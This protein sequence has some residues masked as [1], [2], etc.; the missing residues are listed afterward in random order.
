MSQQKSPTLTIPQ[1]PLG[2]PA[3]T[4]Y[5]YGIVTYED[6]FGGKRYMRFRLTWGGPDK[7]SFIK[8]GESF[9]VLFPNPEGNE[10][11]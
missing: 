4:I 1:L 6:A 11:N 9:G 2:T 10:A 7:R 3:S 8:D 5:I